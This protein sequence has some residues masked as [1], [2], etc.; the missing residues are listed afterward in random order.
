MKKTLTCATAVALLLLTV[1]PVAGQQVCGRHD[2]MVEQ[3]EEKYGERR[4]AYA[5]TGAGFLFE[6]LVS[7]ETETWSLLVTDTLGRSCLMGSGTGWRVVE[8]NPLPG[9]ETGQ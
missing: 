6:I 9:Q 8:T 2:S 5:L 7:H 3:L 4:Y 1:S